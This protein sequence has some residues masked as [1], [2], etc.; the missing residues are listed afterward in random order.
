MK[1]LLISALLSILA[2]F[3][4][5]PVAAQPMEYVRI[6]NSEDF[7]TGFFY[8]PG[9]ETCYNPDTGET[10][11]DTEFGI[12]S[13]ESALAELAKD[14]NEGVAV[15]LSLPTAIVEDGDSF[16][17]AA[18]VGTF[19]GESAFGIG[20]AI[21]AGDGLSFNGAMG[22]GLSRGTVGGRAGVNFSW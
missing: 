5:Q 13:G 10:K 12:V 3:A 17:A 19:N 1:P 11:Q 22:V 2:G 16:A 15:S 7:G 8:I 9:T 4:V 18:S 6:C 14:A 20:G 21:S